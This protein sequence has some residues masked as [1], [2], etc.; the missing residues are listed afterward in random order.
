MD[1]HNQKKM[2]KRVNLSIEELW[3]NLLSR[4]T[5]LIIAA[6]SQLTKS[7]QNLVLN[8]LQKMIKEEGWLPTQMISA[9]K[10]LSS[11]EM[12]KKGNEK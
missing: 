11:I 10:A 2:K 12:I 3:D 6:F 9:Q 4:D 5:E 7:E 1:K 8:H